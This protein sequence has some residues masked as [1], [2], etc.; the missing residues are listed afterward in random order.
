MLVWY[1]NDFLL[2][3]QMVVSVLSIYP[4]LEVAGLILASVCVVKLAPINHPN[5]LLTS[6]EIENGQGVYIALRFS[7][8]LSVQYLECH[9][10]SI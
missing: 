2:T 3:L 7:S 4:I 9:G 6:L 8:L 10:N 1:Y 5:L